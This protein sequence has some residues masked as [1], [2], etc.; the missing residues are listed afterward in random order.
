MIN[1]NVS[2]PSIN[3][4][5]I[6]YE[7]EFFLIVVVALVVLGVDVVLLVVDVVD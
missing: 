3:K 6:S 2:I 7:P 5:I 1:I 4:L